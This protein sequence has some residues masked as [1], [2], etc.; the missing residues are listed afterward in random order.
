MEGVL[1][2][3]SL[4]YRYKTG[5]WLQ[6]SPQTTTIHN[7]MR[8]VRSFRNFKKV[9]YAT[10]PVTTGQV[11]YDERRKHPAMPHPELLEKVISTNYHLGWRMVD[12]LALQ[13]DHPIIFPADL[14]PVHQEWEQPHFLALWLS[15][16]AEVCTDQRLGDGWHFSSGS[17][18]EF[19][20]V[21]QLKLGL[22][23]HPKLIFYNTKSDEEKERE[24]MRSII[25]YDQEG[26]TVSILQGMRQIRSAAEVIAADGFDT[27]RL[28]HCVELLDWTGDMI[29]K[30]FYQ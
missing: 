23:R 14:T 29:D 15:M 5:V 28:T 10:V 1:E 3:K 20:H 7:I 8:T 27:R 16:V 25:P 19:V 26:N 18:E 13:Q 2:S 24:R 17:A 9:T 11:Y 21:M 4:W 22:P 30:G 12:R 6:E